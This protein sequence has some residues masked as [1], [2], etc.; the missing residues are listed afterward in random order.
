MQSIYA[1]FSPTQR[2]LCSGHATPSDFGSMLALAKD[3]IV[4]VDLIKEEGIGPAQRDMN[5]RRIAKSRMI[6]IRED[7][8][9]GGCSKQADCLGSQK[10][11][12]IAVNFAISEIMN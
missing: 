8:R 9:L 12:S 2:V 11:G 6:G 3:L 10:E 1:H 4:T 7:I 5:S